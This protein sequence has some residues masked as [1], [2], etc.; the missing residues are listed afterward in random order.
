MAQLLISKHK[1]IWDVLKVSAWEGQELGFQ[2]ESDGETW[3][4]KANASIALACDRNLRN[5]GVV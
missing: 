3:R 1:D 2:A 5:V 4:H